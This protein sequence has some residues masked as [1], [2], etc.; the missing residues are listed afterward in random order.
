MQYLSRLVPKHLRKI[1][2]YLLLNHRVLWETRVHYVA[3][4][5]GAAILFS[6]LCGLLYPIGLSS[7]LPQYPVV[8][9]L[10]AIPVSIGIL[11]WGYHQYL[12]SIEK[13]YGN[14]FLSLAQGR[15]LLNILIISTLLSPVFI[16]PNMINARIGGLVS[17]EQLSED[18]HHLNQGALFFST[19][20]ERQAF[21]RLLE[22]VEHTGEISC[23][24]EYSFLG[25]R[26]SVPY[27]INDYKNKDYVP[28]NLFHTAQAVKDFKNQ[29][30]AEM[31][32][33]IELFQELSNKYGYNLSYPASEVLT[34]WKKGSYVELADFKKIK[35]KINEQVRG[36]AKAHQPIW[37][38]SEYTLLIGWVFCGI[39]TLASLANMMKTFTIKELL[40]SGVTS[41]AL[42]I[43]MV[44][45]AALSNIITDINNESFLLIFITATYIT[46]F[47]VVA[48]MNQGTEYSLFK[49]ITL[50]L[51][52]GLSPWAILWGVFFLDEM[53][54]I[55]VNES[56]ELVL[57]LVLAGTVI[58]GTLLL[59]Y[60][61]RRFELLRALPKK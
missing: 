47:V 7:F 41:A 6:I 60:L 34:N 37:S 26:F 50:A 19:P 56:N 48:R 57:S 49:A 5:G 42:F 29:S 33:K 15:L 40:L 51:V 43:T 3:F 24:Q 32:A 39:F 20:N 61:Q 13:E 27:G 45:A 35:T 16:L 14:T 8:L 9:I 54:I 55:H 38:A 4:F 52:N 28:N 36:V 31:L 23:L 1:D 21:Q 58:Y 44:S 25:K 46:M 30:D 2:H 22:C 59:P 11:F 10:T 17:P 18:V 12:Y 53:N